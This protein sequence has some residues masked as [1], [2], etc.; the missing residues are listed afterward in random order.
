M[1]YRDGLGA[2]ARAKGVC[3]V[4]AADIKR[5]KDT[6]NTSDTEKQK[7]M[8]WDVLIAPNEKSKRGNYKDRKCKEIVASQAS[9]FK[10]EWLIIATFFLSKPNLGG[11][12]SFK[13]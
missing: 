10:N 12:I 9:P 8:S 13:F 11:F 3:D 4:V 1:L 5:H 6:E 2:Y 7:V